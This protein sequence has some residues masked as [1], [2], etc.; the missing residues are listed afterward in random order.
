ML[1][2]LKKRL[3][4]KKFFSS[5]EIFDESLSSSKVIDKS[6]SKQINIDSVKQLKKFFQ[7]FEV[8]N[9]FSELLKVILNRLKKIYIDVK[10]ELKNNFIYNLTNKRRRLCIS[11]FCEQKIFRMTHDENQHVDY[12]RC[13][14]RIIDFLYVSRLFKK[15]R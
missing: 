11:T 2:D 15:L 4:L 8:F 13:Y 14:Q 12:Y 9:N 10:F 3:Q 7:S 6:Q 5:S 1:I